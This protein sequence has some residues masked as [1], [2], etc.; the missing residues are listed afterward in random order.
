M[1]FHEENE[2]KIMVA[3]FFEGGGW[4]LFKIRERVM[5]VRERRKNAWEGE[6]EGVAARVRRSVL[7]IYFYVLVI[8]LLGRAFLGSGLLAGFWAR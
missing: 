8:G 7:L 2:R 6:R 3:L 1:G 5:V 4:F